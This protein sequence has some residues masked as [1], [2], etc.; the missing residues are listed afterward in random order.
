VKKIPDFEGK[1]GKRGNEEEKIKT[2]IN[3]EGQRGNKGWGN[4]VLGS[5]SRVVN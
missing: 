1:R 3:R 5:N 2:N 4:K